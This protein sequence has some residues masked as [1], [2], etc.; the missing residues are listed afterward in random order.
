MPV[1]LELHRD[2]LAGRREGFEQRPEV[3]VDGHQAT[4]KQHEGPAGTVHLVVQLQAVHRCVCH[5]DMTVCGPRTHRERPHG[6][7]TDFVFFDPPKIKPGLWPSTDVLGS[8]SD[9]A[10]RGEA[11]QPKRSCRVLAR[12]APPLETPVRYRPQPGV[13]GLV[14]WS[15]SAIYWDTTRFKRCLEVVAQMN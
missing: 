2:H 15:G 10:R 9:K 7:F 4:M 1:A 12:T 8:N 14:R 13:L 5:A 11:R 6:G 3:E